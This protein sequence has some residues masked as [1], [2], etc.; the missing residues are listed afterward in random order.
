MG[1]EEDVV[2]TDVFEW[3]S[4]ERVLL[5]ARH[6]YCNRGAAILKRT[7]PGEVAGVSDTRAKVSGVIELKELPM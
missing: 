3:C 2:M 4:G 1:E 5:A 7:D 6:T